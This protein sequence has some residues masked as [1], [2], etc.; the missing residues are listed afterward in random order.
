MNIPSFVSILSFISFAGRTTSSFPE[1]SKEVD[2]TDGSEFKDS[3]D[4]RSSGDFKPGVEKDGTTTIRSR[5]DQS[6]R[7]IQVEGEAR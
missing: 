3:S 5:S 7:D 2:I 1:E 4:R 6:W